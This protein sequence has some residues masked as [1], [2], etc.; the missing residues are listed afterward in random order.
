[1]PMYENVEIP[2][3]A[4]WST[5]FCRWQGALANLHAVRL[6]AYVAKQELAKR[7]IAPGE[8]DHGV[9][10]IT[11]PQQAVFHGLAWLMNQ[12]GAPQAGGPMVAEACATSARAVAESAGE[13]ELG[14]AS[15]SLSLACDRV[16][17][18]PLVVYP[19]PQNVDG[20]PDTERWIMD[21]LNGAGGLVDFATEPMTAVAENCAREWQIDTGQQN[22]VTLR[23]FE[24][25]QDAVKDDHAFHKRYMT[26]PFGVPD[27]AFKKTVGTLQGDEGVPDT[28]AEKLARLK[29]VMDGGTITYGGQTRPADGNAAIVLATPDKARALSADPNI[30]I[31][32]LSFG[33]ARTRFKMMPH[34]PVPASQRAL[35]AAGIGLKDITAIKSH[36]PFA[37]N[38]I[39]FAKE[40]GADL[41]TMNN[42]GCSLVW[43]HPNGPTG[44]RLIVELVEELVMRGGGYGLFHGC[45]AGDQGMAVVVKV[46]DRRN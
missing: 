43:G 2:Y 7:E 23:R 36:N 15:C 38:D 1:M 6:A 40:T 5:P 28:S 29:P 17:N 44:M 20:M 45:A 34:A 12:I 42:Y 16:S 10:G 25:Y 30:R 31:Q 4:Y 18:A 37:V 26:L 24:Q 21:N 32:V 39:V 3:R 33:Q 46:T 8:F 27:G 22:E 14:A 13:I 35:D 11:T 9:L 19:N 41:R